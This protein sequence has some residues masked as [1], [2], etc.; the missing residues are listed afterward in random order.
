MSNLKNRI[1]YIETSKYR[2]QYPLYFK[3]S[4]MKL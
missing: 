1:E 3:Y 2:V 4:E